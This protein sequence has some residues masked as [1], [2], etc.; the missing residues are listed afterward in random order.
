MKR[1]TL[2]MLL[3]AVMLTSFSC[4]KESTEDSFE[5]TTILEAPQTK[6]IE[7]EILELINDY[8]LSLGLNAL[9]NMTDIKAQAYGHTNYMKA[10]GSISHTNFYQR[11]QS[12]V[13]S[14]GAVNVGE[15]V[16]YAYSSAQAVVNAW[17]NSDSHRENME[18][19]YTNFDI[20]AEQDEDGR[21]YFTN[22]FVKK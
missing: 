21:W 16:A 7:I 15:N 6:Q 19:D 2:V 5:T 22:I 20:S 8:R 11:K 1:P 17:I 18:G 12:L 4:T 9:S 3:F 10:E 13:N 14:A